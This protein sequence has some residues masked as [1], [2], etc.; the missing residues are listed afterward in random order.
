MGWGRVR[1]KEWVRL[2]FWGGGGVNFGRRGLVYSKFFCFLFLIPVGK[3][4]GL[5]WVGVG[6]WWYGSNLFLGELPSPLPL[7]PP[8]QVPVP[9]STS[10]HPS[11]NLL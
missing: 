4:V 5:V 8:A 3:M 9:R 7:H 11:I 1:G 10:P 6:F 2:V